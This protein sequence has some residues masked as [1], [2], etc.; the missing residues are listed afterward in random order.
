M[1]RLPDQ[2]T[3]LPVLFQLIVSRAGWRDE[4]RD[5]TCRTRKV[6][7]GRGERRGVCD[8]VNA[9]M[10]KRDGERERSMRSE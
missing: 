3:D 10:E 4:K 5:I 8:Y 1:R 6:R 7:N 9:V 2:D